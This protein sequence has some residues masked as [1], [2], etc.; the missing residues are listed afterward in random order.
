MTIAAGPLIGIQGSDENVL[1]A[2]LVTAQDPGRCGRWRRGALCRCPGLVHSGEY[3][4]VAAGLLASRAIADE[5]PPVNVEARWSLAVRSSGM[6][7]TD[8]QGG[9]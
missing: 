9:L 5:G 8:R 6:A 4:T 3:A 1:S 7:G 2:A